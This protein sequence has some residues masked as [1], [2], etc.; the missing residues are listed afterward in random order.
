[1]AENNEPDTVEEY[2]PTVEDERQRA[3]QMSLNFH[4]LLG[5]LDRIH[6]A[7]CPGKHAT[8]QT[9]V[10]QAV[11]AAEKIRSETK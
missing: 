11:E 10:E 8:W 9:R 4:W 7:L 2:T 3:D 5:N 1:M 6:R